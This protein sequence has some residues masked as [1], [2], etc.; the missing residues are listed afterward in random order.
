MRSRVHQ[1]NLYKKKTKEFFIKHGYECELVERNTAKFIPGRGIFYKKSDLFSSDGISMNGNNIVFWN[2]KS[3]EDISKRRN[4]VLKEAVA[5]F[6]THA[7]PMSVR[8][9]VVIWAVGS[10]Q[11]EIFDADT[12]LRV[13]L[14]RPS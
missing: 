14:V 8:K 10:R 2:A 7:F 6:R 9:Y 5:S 4:E 1:G 11:P 12:G 13:A 3:T